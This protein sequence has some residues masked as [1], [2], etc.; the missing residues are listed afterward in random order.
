MP[1]QTLRAE[2]RPAVS[3]PLQFADLD[4]TAGEGVSPIQ[5]GSDCKTDNNE[6]SQDQLGA[7]L[8]KH[9]QTAPLLNSSNGGRTRRALYSFRPCSV[10]A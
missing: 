6:A 4:G 7:G 1:R 8:E 9:K 10:F 3:I 5:D 2:S